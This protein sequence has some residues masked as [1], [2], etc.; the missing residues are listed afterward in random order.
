M[1]I[2]LGQSERLLLFGRNFLKHPR[3]LGSVIPS[4]RFL[5]NRLLAPVDW[6]RARVIV[7]YGPGVGTVTTEIL[8]RMAP[9]AVL[10]AIETNADFVRFLG[11]RIQDPRLRLVH[12]SAADADDVLAGAGLERADYVISCIPYTTMPEVTRDLILRKTHALLHPHGTFL[13]FQ[14]T[15][16]VLP[17]LRRLFGIVREEFEL[18]NVM[19]ARLFYCRRNAE[20]RTSSRPASRAPIAGPSAS[21]ARLSDS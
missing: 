16:A 13:T 7:E 12:G 18:R 17:S 2:P 1:R 8:R 11:R 15:R 3:M 5:V 21:A 10:V 9:E 4:S 14:F 19:P 6:T 20:R